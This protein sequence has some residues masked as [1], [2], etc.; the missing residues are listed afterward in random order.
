MLK[1]F[2]SGGKRHKTTYLKLQ[3][4]KWLTFCSFDRSIKLQNK[5]K[6]ERKDN[7]KANTKIRRQAAF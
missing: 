2:G 5:V 4:K 1:S 7:L 6:V 3:K